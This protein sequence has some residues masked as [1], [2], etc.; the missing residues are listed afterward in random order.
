MQRGGFPYSI[1]YISLLVYFRASPSSS[2]FLPLAF[3]ILYLDLHDYFK[4][5]F[6]IYR[7]HNQIPLKCTRWWTTTKSMEIQ[8]Q[9]KRRIKVVG[10]RGYHFGLL[11]WD[12]FSSYAS[13]LAPI[14]HEVCWCTAQMLTF[15][16]LCLTGYVVKVFGGDF[17]S[18][19]QYIFGVPR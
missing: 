2:S 1:P 17:V 7:T 8:I 13:P 3:L 16:I 15:I 9:S 4:L 6:L 19:V 18:L 14:F 11:L 12:H 10:R 5:F